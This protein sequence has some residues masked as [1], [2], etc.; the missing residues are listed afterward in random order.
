MFLLPDPLLETVKFA[1][2]RLQSKLVNCRRSNKLQNIY[3]L[4]H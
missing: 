1:P 2:A 4:G 3:R